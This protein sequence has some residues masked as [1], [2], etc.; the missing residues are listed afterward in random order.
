MVDTVQATVPRFPF[1]HH[2][3]DPDEPPFAAAADGIGRVILPTGQQAWVV[4]RHDQLRQMLRSPDFS[5]DFSRPG[6]PLLRPM[7]PETP[8]AG[9]FIRMDPPEHTRFR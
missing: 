3:I 9:M 5:S 6:F 8:R 2:G 4:T 1:G 7:P